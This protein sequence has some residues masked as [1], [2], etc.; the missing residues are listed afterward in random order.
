VATSF[1]GGSFFGSEFFNVAAV[2]AAT[3]EV[4]GGRGGYKPWKQAWRQELV[5]LL[6]ERELKPQ[7]V[8]KPVQKAI[9]RVLETAPPDDT[10]AKEALRSELQG[11]RVGYQPRYVEALRYE[12]AKQYQRELEQEA[13]RLEMRER[14]DEEVLLLILH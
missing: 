11:L 14:D 4:G 6:A 9:R 5:D 1:F 12:I 8:P 13:R 7:S 3:P 2:V 10:S